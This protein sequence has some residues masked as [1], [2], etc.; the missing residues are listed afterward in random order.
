MATSLTLESAASAC[1]RR[2]GAAVAA[3]DQ[4]DP[5]EIAA[6]RVNLRQSG[7]CAGDGRG[8]AGTRGGMLIRES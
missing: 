6:G 7:H 4:A 5:Q 2:A 8:S 1:A 3:A